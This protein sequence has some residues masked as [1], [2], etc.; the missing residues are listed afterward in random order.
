MSAKRTHLSACVASSA[1]L[2][3]RQDQVLLG[4]AVFSAGAWECETQSFVGL[5]LLSVEDIPRE[6]PL[7][8]RRHLDFFPKWPHAG[9][10]E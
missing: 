8:D 1:H 4:Q 2:M 10:A 9:R 7:R 5:G 6:T 3:S